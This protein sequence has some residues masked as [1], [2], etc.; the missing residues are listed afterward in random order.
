MKKKYLEIIDEN[1]KAVF[2]EINC[3]YLPDKD[4]DS[5]SDSSDQESSDDLV[6]KKTK[7]MAH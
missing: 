7:N 2:E 4:Y 6:R 5:E 1:K 3:P